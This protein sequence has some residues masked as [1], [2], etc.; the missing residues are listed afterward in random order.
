[1]LFAPVFFR[2]TVSFF[3]FCCA[4]THEYLSAYKNMLEKVFTVMDKQ[5]KS[6]YLSKERWKHILKE[7]PEL[8]HCLSEV[9]QTLRRPLKVTESE[10]DKAIKYYYT[11][12][13]KRQQQAKYLLAIVKYLNGAGYIITAYFV[14]YIQ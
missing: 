10:Y 13:K 5:G 12:Q 2:N 4:K 6:I 11:Y 7:H 9:Q 14:R 1:M 8:S 3:R